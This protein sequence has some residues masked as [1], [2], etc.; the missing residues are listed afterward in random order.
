MGCEG[1]RER[2]DGKSILN[3]PMPRSAVSV[4]IVVGARESRVH[5]EGSQV[6]GTT[7]YDS[8]ECEGLGILAD[9]ARK[10]NEGK[11]PG[12]RSPCAVKVART[13]T[14]GGMKKWVGRD[15]A[16]S[17]PTADGGDSGALRLGI[18]VRGWWGCGPRR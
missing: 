12:T 5:G 14:T 2:R 7:T 18:Q 17:P 15:R 10:E 13:V 4:A 6:S 9:V 16:P 11:C 3:P 1:E 8:S